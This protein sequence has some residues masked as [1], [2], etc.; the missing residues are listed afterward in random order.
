MTI[1]R[2]SVRASLALL[3]AAALVLALLPLTTPSARADTGAGLVIS[4]VYG[5]GGNS[6]A[7]LNADF[8]EL[9][10]RSAEPIDLDG[11]SV[12][13]A[14]ATGTGNFGANA[15]LLVVLPDATIPPGGYFLVGLAGGSTGDDLPMP[16]ATGTINAA[17][18]AGK[19]VIAE[20]TD[21]LGCNGGSTPCSPQQEARIIDLVGYGNANYFEGEGAAP[22]LNNSTAAFRLSDGC[23][24]T[25]DNAA[26]FTSGAPDPRTSASP[27]ID[28]GDDT[29]P[30]PPPP[31]LTLACTAPQTITEGYSEVDGEFVAGK[32]IT[33]TASNTDGD[34]TFTVAGVDPAPA[35]GELL[36]TS[37][38]DEAEVR[39]SDE[40]PGLD[41]TE[42]SGQYTVTIEA[43]EGDDTA[44]CSVNVRVVPVLNLGELRGVVPDDA[45]GREHV[46]PYALGSPIFQPGPAIATV[47]V[48]TQR[49]L[50]ENANSQFDFEG[51]FIQSLAEDVDLEDL[52]LGDLRAIEDLVAD[53]DARTSD[54]LWVS[55]GTF[56]TV[57]PDTPTTPPQAQQYRA[58]PGD[59]VVLRGPIVE[60]FQQTV[61]QNPFVVDVL[62]ADETG[63]DLDTDIEVTEANPPDDAQQASVYWERL[64]GMQVEVPAGAMAVG[65]TDRFD[66]S[67]AE[68]WVIRGDHPVALRDDPDARR[69]FRDYHP[70]AHPLGADLEERRD[71]NGYR[72][73]LGSFGIKAAQQD[74]TALITPMRTGDTTAETV[75]G[76]LFFA[77]SKYQVMVQEQPGRV[78]GPDPSASSLAA[79]D[80]FDPSDEYAVMVYNVFNLY[81]F[82]DDPL[83]D[84]D[85]NPGDSPDFGPNPGCVPDEGNAN[86]PS[87]QPT[88]GYAPRSQEAY[89]QQRIAIAEQIVDALQAPDV[90]TIQEAE[91]QDVC[92][93]VYDEVNPADSFMDCDLSPAAPGETMENTDRGSG[94]PD[95]AE[96]LALEIFA[97]TDGEI[98]Y[99][100]SGD[101]VHGRDV[102]GITQAFLHRTDRVELV[103]ADELEDDPVL[104][105]GDAI[106]IAYP[107][108]DV[109]TPLAPW[110][111]AE[112]ANPKSINA[113]LT[114]EAIALA[115]SLGESIDGGRFPQTRYVFTRGV[116]VA[117]FRIFPDGVD[118]GGPYVER[119]ITS[120]HMSAVPDSR[121]AQRREQA[122]L[123]AAVNEAVVEAGG[124]VMNTGDFNVFPRPDDPFPRF[125]TDPDREPSDQL[126]PLY[127]RGFFNLHDVIIEELPANTY[128]FIFQGISQILDHIFV[129]QDT[130][131]ELVVA[132]FVHVNIDFPAETPGFEPGRGASDHDPLYARFL[133]GLDD[134]GPEE[135]E[136]PTF[137]SIRDRTEALLDEGRIRPQ[138]AADVV[139]TLDRAERFIDGPQR[140]A[141]IAQLDALI[142][143]L[144]S[145]AAAAERGAGGPI[146]E[147]DPV[148]LRALAA[149]VAALRASLA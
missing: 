33:A 17:A 24:D 71:Q 39:F 132:R 14:S 92:V 7:P 104:G 69:V 111:T 124:R 4:Q 65:G 53:G 22:T 37:D 101:A 86:P 88:F 36:V 18:G 75:Q 19:F 58:E 126:A 67:T 48:V 141:A 3:C 83:S 142:R 137:D 119:Y 60:D 12:Q 116:Q 108:Q 80:G 57:R 23:Q 84:C 147:Q 26:D 115:Q 5:G 100:A 74:A 72:I 136:D 140:R 143:R 8:V 79:V 47:G 121:T 43:A 87:N 31:G 11:R 50:E 144:E 138:L 51:F 82:R 114:D 146:G 122:R 99:E 6:G 44:T 35:A 40:V 13:Y 64:A 29:A 46:S 129:D 21:G 91:K 130:L 10:N 123:N 45:D 127:E 109:R 9:F 70:L 90:I 73:L 49:T 63:V 98:R 112:A 118:S 95:T 145:E 59:I 28:C 125:E 1:A 120:N 30:P 56:A 102:R 139:R 27:T 94:A 110:V 133:F 89:D 16:D 66:P 54:G 77:F 148:A 96:E 55:T 61:L 41:P 105:V 42:G 15:G 52:D 32:A 78:A 134:E 81:D 76:G 38:G 113:E 97:R 62:R 106:D 85:V 20:G 93:P 2:P 149:D 131:E 128:S 103:P 107:S 135:P 117:K 34:V 68:T 25:D